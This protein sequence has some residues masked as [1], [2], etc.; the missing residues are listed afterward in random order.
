MQIA[1]WTPPATMLT[2]SERSCSLE[3][4]TVLP[5]PRAGDQRPTERTVVGRPA[6]SAD[7]L[8][9]VILVDGPQDRRASESRAV[10]QDL[11][12]AFDEFLLVPGLADRARP[13]HQQIEPRAASWL[14]SRWEI[15]STCPS[16]LGGV[17]KL[18][19]RAV[20]TSDRPA[21]CTR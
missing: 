18:D 10:E 6:E 4:R 1:D 13:I 20:A 5:G 16:S 19:D 21:S 8:D 12:H 17:V 11:Q 14:S 7:D 9:P 2:A 15:C 3:S